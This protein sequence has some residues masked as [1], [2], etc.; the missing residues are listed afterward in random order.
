M[1]GNDSNHLELTGVAWDQKTIEENDNL[2]RRWELSQQTQYVMQVVLNLFS[3]FETDQ[4]A[5]I[6]HT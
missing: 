1:F 3:S 5:I 2:Q 4:N 6:A